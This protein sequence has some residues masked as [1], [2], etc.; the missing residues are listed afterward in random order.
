MLLREPEQLRRLLREWRTTGQVGLLSAMGSACLF[1]GFASGPVALVRTIA[2]IE[3]IFSLMFSRFF[4]KEK[5]RRPEIMGLLI[6]TA[7][8]VLSLAG[9][10]LKPH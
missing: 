9:G 10:F 8:V 4:L 1:L 3:V 6:V 2:Q 7:G 5:L